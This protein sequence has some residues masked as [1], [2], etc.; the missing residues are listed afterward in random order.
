[1]SAQTASWFHC[2]V[3]PISRSAGRS[4]VAAA[5][6]RFGVLLEDRET[7]LRHDYTRRSG[8]EATFIVTPKNAPS[9]SQDLEHLWNEAQNADTRKNSR[10]ARECELALPNEVSAAA[11]EN[12]ARAFA[13]HLVERYGVGVAVAVHAPSRQGDERNYHAHI[14]FTTRSLDAEG[15]GAKTRVLD[16]KATGA[17]E[18]KHLREVA[19]KLINAALEEAGRQERVDHRSFK[20]RGID[21]EATQHLGPEAAAMES[22]GKDSRIGDHN[23]QVME[24]NAQREALQA[25]KSALDAAIETA[26]AEESPEER[27]HRQ[28]SAFACPVVES[29]AEDL[30]E[31]G[32]VREWGLG[33]LLEHTAVFFTG[34]VYNT[35]QRIK[36]TWQK[37]ILDRRETDHRPREPERGEH[38][39]ER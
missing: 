6:Y 19:C 25:E 26:L 28:Q 21:K 2:S 23:R 13:D 14:L 9:W 38:E 17:Q 32:K 12:I 20:D 39:F 11:R 29:F 7:L 16:A 15:L 36:D 27:K 5:A 24:V 18:V 22:K 4:V 30:K 37:Y 31:R 8:V 3:K 1:M 33:G 34:L 10:L 35:A